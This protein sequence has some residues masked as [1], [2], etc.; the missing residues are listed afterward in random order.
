MVNCIFT[1][2]I[3]LKFATVTRN[4]ES[5]NV[6]LAMIAVTVGILNGLVP[7]YRFSWRKTYNTSLLCCC[8]WR[9]VFVCVSS[10]A[11]RHRRCWIWR[12]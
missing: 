7:A 5:Y 6:L 11:S 4:D 8:C 2:F 12:C 1:A 3:C 10:S 9:C